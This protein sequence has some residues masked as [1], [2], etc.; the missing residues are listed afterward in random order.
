MEQAIK[1]VMVT[2][3]YASELLK[4]NTNNRPLR[5]SVVEK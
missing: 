5:N 4:F 2:P 3:E 1:T